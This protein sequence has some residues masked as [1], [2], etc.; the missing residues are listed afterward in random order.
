MLVI[1]NVILV[2]FVGGI[3]IFIREYRIK[4]KSHEKQ[5]N[6]I[7]LQHKKELMKTQLEI[8]QQTMADIGREIHDNV[9]QKLTL[10]SMYLQRLVFENKPSE[11]MGNLNEVNDI[12]NESL[13]E[14][15]HLSKS[16]T[17]DTIETNSFVDLIEMECEK[18]RKLKKYVVTFNSTTE[19]PPI[20]YQTKSILL[21]IVQEFFQNSIKHSGCKAL[22]I[23]LEK[24]HHA[25]QLI[26]S[27]DGIGF[28]LKHLKKEGIGLK[29]IRKRV[30]MI[31]GISALES[32]KES[33]TK[34]SVKIPI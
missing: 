34:L 13:S 24:D 29:N 3:I 32:N 7:D 20:D 6:A 5:L 16:L 26:L 19:I 15:R 9:G 25:L 11:L 8:Q 21:R 10:S 22:Q 28:D 30:E 17:D 1:F 31:Q 14:L 33:G 23:S 2:A 18:L 12:I 4:K 27:D